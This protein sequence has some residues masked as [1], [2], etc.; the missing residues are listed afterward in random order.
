[1]KLDSHLYLKWIENRHLKEDAFYN[2]VNS[3]VLVALSEKQEVLGFTAFEADSLDLAFFHR[4]AARQTRDEYLGVTFILHLP[5]SAKSSAES[6]MADLKI[7]N[8]EVHETPFV[9]IKKT[10]GQLSFRNKLRI[11]N[12]D[13][14]PVMLKFLKNALTELKFVEVIGQVTDPLLASNE[15]KN[16]QPDLVTM[17]IQMAPKS[18]VELVKEMF[19]THYFP[20]IMISSLSLE[21]GSAVFEALK[22]GAFD[23][24]QKPKFENKENFIEELKN[25]MLLAVDFV[26]QKQTLHSGDKKA[27]MRSINSGGAIDSDLIWCLG[28]STGGTRALTEILSS[29]PAAI[30]PTLIVQHIPPIFSKAFADSLN[31]HCA[32]SVSEAVDGEP[33]LPNH[34][35]IAQGGMQMGVQRRATDRKLYLTIKDA[36]AMSGFK[37]SVDYLFKD[38]AALSGMKVVAAVLTGMGKDGAEGLLKLKNAGAYTI[39][40]DEKTSAVYGM[41]KQAFDLGAS[42]EV[43]ALENV[44]EVLLR[45]SLVR[46]SS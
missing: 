5:D 46:L 32:F 33:L 22:A 8:V 34:V 42:T 24:V 7:K 44:A 20:T 16:L 36:P 9:Q 6:L 19:Q 28:A 14:S 27:G 3:C 18:G 17:D 15:I 37:P 29:L 12:V 13:D 1:M 23:F 30:P 11:M 43:V 25:K 4:L 45:R 21:E 41:P 10:C 39:T 26:P 35:Y 31:E 2:F 40:Q 38:V